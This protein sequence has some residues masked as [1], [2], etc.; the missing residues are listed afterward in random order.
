MNHYSLPCGFDKIIRV[1]RVNKLLLTR[2]LNRI[3]AFKFADKYKWAI[4]L[5]LDDAF[6][7]GK[8][9]FE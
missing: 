9:S 7:F 6:R 4:R 1:M 5:N 3:S 8:Y 2:S